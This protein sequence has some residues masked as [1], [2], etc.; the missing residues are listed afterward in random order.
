MMKFAG[1]DILIDRRVEANEV[2]ACLAKVFGLDVG[3]VAVIDDIANYPDRSIADLVCT[4][5]VLEGDFVCLLSMDSRPKVLEFESMVDLV[6]AISGTLAAKCL[7]PDDETLNPYAMW[8]M[9]PG[10][11]PTRTFLNVD[12]L[13]REIY[14]LAKP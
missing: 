7:V 8:L 14:V 11:S 13:E 12:A 6:Q 10:C 4:R 5:S 2:Q 9:E 3:R 1:V